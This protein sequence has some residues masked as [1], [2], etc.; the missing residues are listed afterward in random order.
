VRAGEHAA[1]DHGVREIRGDGPIVDACECGG[2]VFSRR[3]IW[4]PLIPSDKGTLS[5]SSMRYTASIDDKALSRSPDIWHSLLSVKACR[6]YGHVLSGPSGK[7]L[8]MSFRCRAKSPQLSRE[9]E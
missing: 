5:D 6:I 7:F 4:S 1:G 2:N 3:P 8:I 9:D